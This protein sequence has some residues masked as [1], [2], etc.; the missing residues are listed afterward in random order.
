[1]GRV[2]PP[3]I[4]DETVVC[5]GGLNDKFHPQGDIS[6]VSRELTSTSFMMDS[7]DRRVGEPRVAIR[8]AAPMDH[9]TSDA[10]GLVLAFFIANHVY[11]Y[12][13][14]H[15]QVADGTGDLGMAKDDG[16]PRRRWLKKEWS[17][18]LPVLQLC[19]LNSAL[20]RLIKVL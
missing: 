7:T 10:I 11:H 18:S 1:M 17:M 19:S 9:K 6:H 8:A 20:I 14:P 12:R 4:E 3:L 15:T 5:Y 13:P 2:V 16:C